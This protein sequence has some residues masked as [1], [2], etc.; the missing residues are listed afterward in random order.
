LGMMGTIP[1]TS[2]MGQ[3]SYAPQQTQQQQ[4]SQNTS[5]PVKLKDP[6]DDLLNM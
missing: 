2:P 3:S 5:Q 1:P 6:F 4:R